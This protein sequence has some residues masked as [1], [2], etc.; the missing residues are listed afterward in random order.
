MLGIYALIPA[1]ALYR[2][3]DGC[4]S[5]PESQA[6]KSIR[7]KVHLHAVFSGPASSRSSPFR[8]S[9]ADRAGPRLGS[10]QTR[11]DLQIGMS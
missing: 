1:I 10:K 8:S 2:R 3:N 11:S 5:T 4:A 7:R 9:W 6:G